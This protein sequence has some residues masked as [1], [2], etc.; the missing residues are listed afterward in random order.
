MF[1]ALNNSHNATGSVYAVVSVFALVFFLLSRKGEKAYYLIIL[2]TCI[3]ALL[4]TKS[5][6]ALIGF[7]AGAFIAYCIHEKSILRFFRN[8]IIVI[9]TF[10]PIV[11]VTGTYGR[12]I[13]IFHIKDLSALMRIDM[14][15]K[16]W[17]MFT[18][19]P[20]FGIG[21]GRYNDAANY[22][23]QNIS[24]GLIGKPGIFSIYNTSQV[25][26]DSSNAHNSYLQL[27]AETGIIGLI[28]MLAFWIL[29]FKIIFKAYKITENNFSKKTY[30]AVL[31]GIITLFILSLTEHYM[32]N[33]TVMVCLSIA[34]S[35][36]V[37][38]AW[39]EKYFK[40]EEIPHKELS[41]ADK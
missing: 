26:F 5:R 19:S 32:A 11:Y 4:I 29:C 25:I 36:A 33:P 2:L 3:V 6:G 24:A 40:K 13:Q 22:N 12:I 28:L 17:F 27:L 14:W 16:A 9:I 8:M 1:I 37:G 38:L 18:Q 35:F 30:L 34:I 23:I 39:Q 15:Q 7:A 20:I 41:Y 31:G 10:I 21:F